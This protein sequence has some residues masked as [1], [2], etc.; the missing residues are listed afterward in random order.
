MGSAPATDNLTG[1]LADASGKVFAPG[2]A[3]GVLTAGA[4]T[5]LSL[6]FANAQ[7]ITGPALYF[8][9]IVGNGTDANNYRTVAAATYNNITSQGTTSITFGTFPDFTPPVTFTADLAPVI[10]LYR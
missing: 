6:P 9:S 7:I 8:A 10:C 1:Q 4:N 5:F 2:A 3:A